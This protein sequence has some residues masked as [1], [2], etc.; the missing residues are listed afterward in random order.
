MGTFV[1][2][3]RSLHQ[4]HLLDPFQV[5]A[6]LSPL[7]LAKLEQKKRKRAR[8]TKRKENKLDQKSDW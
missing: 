5:A 2:L 7:K 3:L 8:S 4:F 1:S 6:Q